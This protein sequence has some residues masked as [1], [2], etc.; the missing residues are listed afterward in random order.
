MCFIFEVT[1][2]DRSE[3]PVRNSIRVVVVFEMLNRAALLACLRSLVETTRCRHELFAS[4]GESRPSESLFADVRSAFN[5]VC[6]STDGSDWM[7][8]LCVH[9]SYTRRL[10]RS[11]DVLEHGWCTLSI[12][13]GESL[14]VSL[15][16]MGCQLFVPFA[17]MT[18]WWTSCN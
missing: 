1:R 10:K 2:V 6:L 14:M 13:P 18:L 15:H 3:R 8:L 7:S 17:K 16:D 11:R 9:A 4:R 5:Y 12:R